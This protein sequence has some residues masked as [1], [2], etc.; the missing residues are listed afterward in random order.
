L[1][2]VAVWGV[3]R[4][5]NTGRLMPAAVAGAAMLVYWLF[6][7]SF[8][9]VAAMLAAIVLLAVV[10][11]TVSWKRAATTSGVL[12]FV[13]AIGWLALRVGTGLDLVACMRVAVA[14][15]A[16]QQQNDPYWPLK[17]YVI[18]STG[19]LLAYAL[20]APTLFALSIPATVMLWPTRR[21]PVQQPKRLH[22]PSLLGPVFFATWLTV[23]GAGFSG[24]FWLETERIW[25]FLT[26]FLAIPA[27]VGLRSIATPQTGDSDF[28]RAAIVSILSTIVASVALL[29]TY[30]MLLLP[31][32]P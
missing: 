27:A 30:E 28:D 15:H 6:S 9:I 18:R 3:V 26:P 24:L 19:N 21:R 29:A 31:Y 10:T 2:V 4:A 25:T 11:H 17:A 13:L 22:S 8:A 16:L 14:Q 1:A 5:L 12:A 7:F 32:V 20:N 23:L